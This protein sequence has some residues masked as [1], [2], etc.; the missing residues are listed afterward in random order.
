MVTLIIASC[1]IVGS[2]AE[3][4]A[5]SQIPALQAEA[6]AAAEREWRDRE[7]KRA[8]EPD[9]AIWSHKPA[10][11]QHYDELLSALQRV[12]DTKVEIHGHVDYCLESDR[13]EIHAESMTWGSP[14][15]D[16]CRIYGDVGSLSFHQELDG[17]DCF[18]GT[19]SGHVKLRLGDVEA[20]ADKLLFTGNYF[21]F[22]GNVRLTSNC[23][24][25][26]AAMLSADLIHWQLDEQ[27]FEV[28]GNGVF[29]Q[30]IS[31]R[32]ACRAQS[33]RLPLEIFDQR[34]ADAALAIEMPHVA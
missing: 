22:A 15:D 25:P 4:E 31:G 33:R 30:P 2:E 6:Q 23:S 18:Q 19:F 26:Q 3:R 12:N 10:N 24:E 8:A 11:G 32:P 34:T 21:E 1:A 9:L 28:R 17:P 16:E 20:S 29:S 27:I 13:I 14:Q 7:A 5:Q